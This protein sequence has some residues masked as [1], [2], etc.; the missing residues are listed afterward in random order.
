MIEKEYDFMKQESS[1]PHVVQE[2][3]WATGDLYNDRTVGGCQLKSQTVS[4]RSLKVDR[5]VWKLG[6]WKV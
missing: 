3:D 4:P 5:V 1:Q 6:P 2:L